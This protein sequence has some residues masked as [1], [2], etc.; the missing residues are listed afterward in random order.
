MKRP[1]VS[2]VVAVYNCEKY[3][4]RCLD[5][6]IS[7]N[8]IDYEIIIIDDGST[9]HSYE[10]IKHLL[11]NKNINYFKK[12]NGGLSSVRNYGIKV[13]KGTYILNIDGDDYIS[14][15]C[16]SNC[17]NTEIVK[18]NPD[19]IWFGLDTVYDNG[20]SY[21]HGTKMEYRKIQLSSEQVMQEL[22]MNHLKNMS[23]QFFVKRDV[24]INIKEPVY[25]V[26]IYY[27]DLASTYKIVKQSKKIIFVPGIYYH[28]VQHPGTITNSSSAKKISDVEKI[29][30]MIVNSMD[31]VALKKNWTYSIGLQEYYML[32][33]LKPRNKEK[34]I[35][36]REVVLEN[37]PRNKTAYEKLIY[38]AM[39]LRILDFLKIIWQNMQHLMLNNKKIG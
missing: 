11:K 2:I 17:L 19:M 15:N 37:W 14:K 5:S 7:Q 33:N 28:Y 21:P 12:D 34:L 24:L 38:V 27:E 22:S 32:L 8:F 10:K 36:I 9:D 25:P 30:K 16:L 18:S 4:K 35:S 39:K 31:T 13:A 26:G 29:R 1:L 6:I 23:V 3:I 20:K